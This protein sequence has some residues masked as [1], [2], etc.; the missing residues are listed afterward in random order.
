MFMN[1]AQWTL[2]GD[3]TTLPPKKD[4]A[5]IVLSNKTNDTG[6][7]LRIQFVREMQTIHVYGKE[8]YHNLT[9]YISPVP[10]DNRYD[11]YSKYKY[12]L[13]VENNSEINYATEKIWEPL[14]CE[15]LPFYWGC[16]NLETY[17]DPQA[18]VRLPLEDPTKASEIV[19]KAVEEDWWSQRIDA[20]RS[21]KQKIINELGFFPRIRNIIAPT[22]TMKGIVLT[23]HSSKDRIPIV[24]KLRSNMTDIGIK[25]EIFYGVNGKD[26]IIS[27]TKV[28]YNKETR[29]YDPK[30]R[31][32]GQKMTLGEFGCAWSHIKIYQKLLEDQTTDN[33]LVIEDDA[34]IVGDLNILRELPLDF[35]VAHVAYSEW[36]PF[37]KTDPVNRSYFNIE[38]KFFNHTTAYVV[39]KAG[40]RKLLDYIDTNINIPA[41]DLLSNSFIQG[42]IQ[43][44]VPESPIFTF[45]KDIASTIDAIE[46]R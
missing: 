34:Q 11:V 9:S 2:N 12:V 25:N 1:P 35:E 39:S 42:K 22:K 32:N 26:L 17:I 15:C 43:V 30:V 10:D 45:T 29:N 4:E 14:M 20:I 46:S 23:L 41:D 21:A 19:R 36:Y 7:N 38:K 40:A 37:V 28:V 27:N 13:A 18:F 8:N 16:P 3:L 33:Y 44:I 24:E 5:A 31:L 6:H